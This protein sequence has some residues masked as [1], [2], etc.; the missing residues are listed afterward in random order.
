MA[1]N[2]PDY[3]DLKFSMADMNRFFK[4]QGIKLDTL[5]KMNLNSVFNKYDAKNEKKDGEIS[6][7]DNRVRFLGELEKSDPEIFDKV[8]SFSIAVE[9]AED[10]RKQ[11]AETEKEFKQSIEADKKAKVKENSNKN[12]IFGRN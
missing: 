2:I 3:S 4:D 5:Q 10:L 12:T 8:V 11:K 1:G 6:K 7:I 9:Q